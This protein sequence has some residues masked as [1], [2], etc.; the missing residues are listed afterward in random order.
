LYRVGIP[1]YG[2]SA[3]TLTIKLYYDGSAS[4]SETFTATLGAGTYQS[5]IILKPA[6]QKC[7]TIAVEI[8]EDATNSGSAD[9]GATLNGLGLLVAPRTVKMPY[10]VA[11]SKVPAGS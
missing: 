10:N 7:R 4:T 5:E 1:V 6:K 11:V 2:H 8:E 9:R 3:T